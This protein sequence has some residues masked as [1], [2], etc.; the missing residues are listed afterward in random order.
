MINKSENVYSFK[1]VN[2]TAVHLKTP[3]NFFAS[4]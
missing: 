1:I 4:V 3:G 2:N